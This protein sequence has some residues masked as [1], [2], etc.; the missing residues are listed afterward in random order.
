MAPKLTLPAKH[1]SIAVAH[2]PPGA[3]NRIPHRRQ[4]GLVLVVQAP[5]Q[6]GRS[7]RTWRAFYS[8]TRDGQRTIR[9]VRLGPSRQCVLLKLGFAP[10]RSSKLSSGA[11]T[12]G[13]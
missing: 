3:G 9:K 13:R 11:T 1:K 8:L 10:P 6:A 7:T 2:T 4:S 5:T 12:S